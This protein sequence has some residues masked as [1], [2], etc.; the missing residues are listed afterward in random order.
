[1]LLPK[2]PTTRSRAIRDSARGEACTFQIPGY[3]NGDPATTVLCHIQFD[4]G[5]MGGKASDLSA[6]YGC[7]GCHD[8]IDGRQRGRVSRED[9]QHYKIR[10]VLRTLE[11]LADK[12]LILIKG[13]AA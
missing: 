3:C 4:G 8:V 9:L 5:V 12:G 2:T 1:M 11:R 7:S 6:A 10:A 13:R